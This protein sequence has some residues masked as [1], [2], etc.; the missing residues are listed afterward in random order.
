MKKLYQFNKICLIIT[1]VLYLTI[2][3]GLYAQIVL[4]GIQILSAL[5]LLFLWHRFNKSDKKKLLIYW[6]LVSIYGVGW[7]LKVDF[8]NFWWLS[9]I[10][11]PMSIATYFVFILKNLKTTVYENSNT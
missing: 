5:S 8:N 9:I 11:I 1:L 7:L 4:G 6:L 2:I 10:I 3:F